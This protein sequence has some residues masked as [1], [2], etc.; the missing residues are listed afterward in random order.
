M[1]WPEVIHN[2]IQAAAFVACLF[3]LAWCTVHAR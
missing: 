3:V 1:K 2:A